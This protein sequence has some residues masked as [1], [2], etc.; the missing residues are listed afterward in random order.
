[1]CVHVQSCP[2]LCHPIDCSPPQT[3]LSMEF[4]RQEYS[5]GVLFSTPGDLRN[6]GIKPP[7][8]VSLVSCIKPP[9]LISPHQCIC[10]LAGRFFTTEPPGKP[11]LLQ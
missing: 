7:F 11:C 8:L 1:M 10:A 3:P 6:S 2:I 5:S 9:F 4:S